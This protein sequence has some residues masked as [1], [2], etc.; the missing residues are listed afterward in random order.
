MPMFRRNILPSSS[1][2]KRETVCFCETL[3]PTD[4]SALRQN[5][6]EHLASCNLLYSFPRVNSLYIPS[7]MKI[8]TISRRMQNPISSLNACHPLIIKQADLD[9]LNVSP[10]TYSTVQLIMVTANP[11]RNTSEVHHLLIVYVQCQMVGQKMN[12]V[13]PGRQQLCDGCTAFTNN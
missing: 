7:I 10:F 4:E 5:P 13:L 2:M 11:F 9:C 8:I 3:E 6:E 12:R 1:G